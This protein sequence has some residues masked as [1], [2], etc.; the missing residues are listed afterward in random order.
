[1]VAFLRLEFS[2]SIILL[3]SSL[4]YFIIEIFFWYSIFDQ[5]KLFSD[6]YRTILD[7]SPVLLYFTLI[8][9]SFL[10]SSRALSLLFCLR[11]FSILNVLFLSVAMVLSKR[12]SDFY[13]FFALL[14]KLKGPFFKAT[15]KVKELPLVPKPI[16]TWVLMFSSKAYWH[17]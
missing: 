16:Y 13:F 15:S 3:L 14:I 11:G 5:C 1:M 10:P 9:S 7:N 12:F 17:W 8:V 6:C 2:I 4:F